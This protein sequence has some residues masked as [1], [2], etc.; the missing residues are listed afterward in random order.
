M[1]PFLATFVNCTLWMKYGLL[2]DESLMYTVNGVGLLVSALCLGLYYRHS[3]DK[4]TAEKQIIYAF[5]FL[6][7]VLSY[8]RFFYPIV[9]TILDQLGLLACVFSIVMFGAPLFSITRV[10]RSGSAQGQLSLPLASLSFA[11]SLSWAL[12]GCV[13]SFLVLCPN[14]DTSTIADS[15]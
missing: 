3:D 6:V 8:V 13:L 14:T 7:S 9:P 5:L 2:L 10:I 11:V 12:V 1:L 15:L 4:V